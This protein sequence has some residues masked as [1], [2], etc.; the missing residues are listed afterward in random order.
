MGEQ[1]AESGLVLEYAD[2]S[3][4]NE[5]NGRRVV[6]TFCGGGA[7]GIVSFIAFIAIL[8]TP[9]NADFKSWPFAHLAVLLAISALLCSA[10]G[11][12]ITLVIRNARHGALR[13][14]APLT[15]AVAGYACNFLAGFAWIVP[16]APFWVWIA[17]LLASSI[18]AGLI[19]SPKPKVQNVAHEMLARWRRMATASGI[20]WISFLVIGFASAFGARGTCERDVKKL[21]DRM[22]FGTVVEIHAHV[23]LP[24]VVGVELFA[25]E[26]E[27][28]KIHYL[29]VLGRRVEF[30]DDLVM[31]A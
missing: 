13:Y 31:A 2:R 18:A 15:S 22:Y 25:P 4:D 8:R 14:R 11:I 26:M 7:V 30:W 16:Y 20:A 5:R 24:F 27:Y 9:L 21:A 6:P 1:A 3:T 23:E 29:C 12:S 19:L 17:A 28:R 10:T